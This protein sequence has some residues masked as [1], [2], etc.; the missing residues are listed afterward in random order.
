M[1]PMDSQRYPITTCTK[2]RSRKS[3]NR[4]IKPII[5][6]TSCNND[7]EVSMDVPKKCN[8]PTAIH[9]GMDLRSIRV[10]LLGA[11]LLITSCLSINPASAFDLGEYS[12]HNLYEM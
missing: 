3:R 11:L 10:M 4:S 2:I 5:V 9:V 12:L 6:K 1:G 8:R 7:K